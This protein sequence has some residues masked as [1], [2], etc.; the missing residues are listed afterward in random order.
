M[1]I[2]YARELNKEQLEVVTGA[3]GPSLVLSGPG[4]GKTRTLVFR[5]LYL[6]E[7][8]VDPREIL[9]VTFTKKAAKEMTERV[10]LLWGTRPQ[11]MWGGTFHHIG[12]LILR[13]HGHHVG[14]DSSF[15]ILDRED[16]RSLLGA[17]MREDFHARKDL[18]KPAVFQELIGLALNS[19]SSLEELADASQKSRP[20]FLETA[21]YLFGRYQERK[22]RQ[23]LLDYDDLLVKWLELLEQNTQVQQQL[24]SRFRYILVD[25]FQDTN[26]IQNE[27]VRL[28]GLQHANVLAV[29]DDAQSIFSFRGA[30]IRNILEFQRIYPGAKVFRLETN[31][32]SSPEILDVANAVIERNSMKL[33]K[34]LHSTK[35]AGPRPQVAALSNPSS[36]A[37]FVAQQIL[38]LLS[39]KEKLSD[40]AV[41]FR[42]RYHAAD[43]ELALSKRNIPYQ[44]R[45]GIRFFEQAHIKD[46][47]AVLRILANRKDEVSWI[48][49]LKL[50]K[51]IGAVKAARIAE[52]AAG[53][54][55][56]EY[57][58][59][60]A[61]TE[62][63]F[64]L[65]LAASRM[66]RAQDVLE[67]T[68]EKWYAEYARSAYPDAESRIE[69]VRQLALMAKEYDGI[70]DMLSALSLSEDLEEGEVDRLT[71][72]T[73]HQ[74]KGLEWKTVF[75]IS[76][77]E[78]EFPYRRGMYK[79]EA[80]EE[81]RRLFYVAITRCK[82]N[83][84]LTYP[85]LSRGWRDLPDSPSSFLLEL[86][87]NLF[88][89]KREQEEYEEVDSRNSKKGWFIP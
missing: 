3:E 64:A 27:I 51:R 87:Q 76:L 2:D 5:T 45:G 71:L 50:Q 8:N 59:S 46:V 34:Q 42:N 26:P 66:K 60:D 56:F 53:M 57:E 17:I 88:E 38:S 10:E 86:D 29:G 37:A 4:T 40:M 21:Q 84:F 19:R 48:R 70:Q 16:T 49:V 47:L 83:L 61:D 68:L 78:G 80:L 18:P 22:K 74:A 33:P 63:V 13:M 58:N 67:Y 12:H 89:Q 75:L 30:S 20:D 7:R 52:I 54:A 43:V 65:F 62:Q 15:G 14:Y 41:L 25:E 82:E 24:S 44:V 85:E 1:R 81:E 23:N 35:P 72:S 6:L 69:D 11:G 73:I 55:S 31:Y 79:Q 39:M 28:M 32:R 77:K 36:E 9:L